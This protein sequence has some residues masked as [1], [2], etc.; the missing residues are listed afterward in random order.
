M[1]ING[2][3]IINATI[4]QSKLNLADPTGNTD[5]VTLQFLNAKLAGL[6]P[7]GSC[8][9]TTTASLAPT[10]FTTTSIT[11]TGGLPTTIDGVTLAVGDRILVKNETL[12]NA[13]ANRIYVYA[14]GNTWQVATDSIVD[15]IATNNT[16]TSGASVVVTEGILGGQ[17][18]YQLT[19]P[20]T[21]IPT[22]Q[23]NWTI[24]NFLQ[25]PTPTTANKNV[26]ASVTTTDFQTTGVTIANTPNNGSYV[27]VFVNGQ[28]QR[29]G[30]GVR[31][32]DCYFS[33][34]G[35]VTAKTFATIVSGD[36]L[37]WVGSVAGFQ[38][39]VTFTIDL[40]YNV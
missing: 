40:D 9:V 18:M 14:V 8:R 35:G 33:S 20:D 31:T 19:T 34:D 11:K 16:L 3:Q 26:V 17:K 32:L 38:L 22:T 5:A 2:S 27:K 21:L 37:Y 15:V 4:T 13:P 39:N 10:S 1:Q 30:N 29:V 28:L 24:T 6:D 36:T 23:L 12:L 25:S 7:K